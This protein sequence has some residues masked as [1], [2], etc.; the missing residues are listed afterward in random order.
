VL[1]RTFWRSPGGAGQLTRMEGSTPFRAGASAD[2][3][4]PTPTPRQ[5]NSP[6]S[7]RGRFVSSELE[8]IFRRHNRPQEVRQANIALGLVI[9]A[10][11]P[12]IP[13]D[14]RVLGWSVL[15][16]VFLACRIVWIG[17]SAAVMTLF[18]RD[19][20][21]SR[22][23]QILVAWCALLGL[24]CVAI[25][26]TRP[27]MYFVGNVLTCI[28]LMLLVYFVLPLPLDLQ[29]MMCLTA[30]AGIGYF[31]I[32]RQV[33]LDPVLQRAVV[34]N[35]LLANFAGALA[36]W[37][38]HRLRRQQFAALQRE[39]VLRTGLQEAL[40]KVKTLQGYLPICAHC[41]SVRNDDGYW[42][43]VEV[44]VREH[45]SAEFTHGI[46]PQ[47]LKEHFETTVPASN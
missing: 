3:F 18:R 39:I 7:V 14:Y 12:F 42:Q 31:L 24:G 47:C 10:T 17:I 36:S 11:L 8:T 2:D 23:D 40:S 46:C 38:L 25:G 37:Y 43:Q 5:L 33:D 1:E 35:C 6:I 9:A 44:Y 29:V 27:A 28:T 21:A 26:F 13:S 32:L 45:T 15:F 16:W 4:Y 20:P 19:L 34:V 22:M 30:L 41:K